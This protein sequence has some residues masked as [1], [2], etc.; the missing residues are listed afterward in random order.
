[1]TSD[2]KYDGEI[3]ESF[4]LVL[5]IGRNGLFENHWSISLSLLCSRR[6]N[7][8]QIRSWSFSQAV[9][10]MCRKRDAWSCSVR[11]VAGCSLWREEGKRG[12]LITDP[13]HLTHSY[14]NTHTLL[15]EPKATRAPCSSAALVSLSQRHAALPFAW[16]TLPDQIVPHHRVLPIV[17]WLWRFFTDISG[18]LP[19]LLI[20]WLFKLLPTIHEMW[21]SHSCC[22]V[23]NFCDF[24]SFICIKSYINSHVHS[25]QSYSQSLRG[26]STR[27]RWIRPIVSGRIW[28]DDIGT[29][30]S[31]LTVDRCCT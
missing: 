23:K 4:L 12:A 14:N 6:Y 31:S 17:G 24:F 13:W 21:F 9:S 8:P 30:V 18:V 11:K 3:E 26:T 15:S 16:T 1:M 28:T 27:I 22:I 7:Q 25:T 20:P 5:L 2:L 29:D 10:T 19:T